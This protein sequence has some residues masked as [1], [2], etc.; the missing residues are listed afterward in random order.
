MLRLVR[1]YI[2]TGRTLTRLSR[3]SGNGRSGNVL[4]SLQC[5]FAPKHGRAAGVHSMASPSLRGPNGLI[6][7]WP[8]NE[9]E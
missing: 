3:R 6:V 5:A 1:G 2:G 7:E 9:A 8:H 4:V